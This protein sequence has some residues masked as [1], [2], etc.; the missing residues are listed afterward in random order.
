MVQLYW[1]EKMDN[2]IVFGGNGFIGTHLI[3]TLGSTCLSFDLVTGSKTSKFCD[4]RETINIDLDNQID[5]IFNFAA[6]HTT[7]KHEYQEYFETNIKGAENICDFARKNNINTIVFTSSIATYGTWEDEMNENSFPLPTSA[8]GISKLLAE[9]VHKRWQSEDKKRKLIILRPGVVF[10]EGEGGNFT[11]L[12]NAIS[13]GR[14][15]YPGRKDTRKSAIYVKDLVNIMV[16]MTKK[17][18]PGCYLYNMAYT[19]NHTIEKICKSI[20]KVTGSNVPRILVPSWILLSSA[21]IINAIGK[22]SG[23][24]FNGIHPDRVKKLLI[25]TDVVGKKILDDGY[26]YQYSLESAIQDWY[27]DCNREKLV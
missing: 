9:E 12:F 13:R 10:G 26:E 6:L 21:Y 15:M 11:R 7:P 16:E 8:Y 2:S 5:I 25:S 27:D 24:S 14:F 18:T 3:R 22:I 4:V 23:L 19:P 1:E 20:A 17:E